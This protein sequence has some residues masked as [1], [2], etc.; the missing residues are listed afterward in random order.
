MKPVSRSHKITNAPKEIKCA[1][2]FFLIL[3]LSMVS[4]CGDGNT[5]LDATSGTGAINFRVHWEG[6]SENQDGPHL[7]DTGDIDCDTVGIDTVTFEA[8]DSNEANLLARQSWS[9]SAHQGSLDGVS[10]GQNRRLLV[11]GKDTL[12]NVIYKGVKT[13]INVVAGGQADV[14]LVTAV[15]EFCFQMDSDEDGVWDCLDNCSNTSNSGQEDEDNDG[16]GDAC[17]SSTESF[18]NSIGM[19]FNYIPSGSFMMGRPEYEYGNDDE[20]QHQVILTKGF[21]MQTTEVTQAQWL[22]IMG[23]NPSAFIHCG[24]DCPVDYISYEDAQEF[25]DA[26]NQKEGGNGHVPPP[27]RSRMGVCGPCGKH[28]GF[29][30][31]KR[32]TIRM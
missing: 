16:I 18:T 24:G 5:E 15:P 3:I 32:D 13:G 20:T 6:A 9:C 10:A 23:T 11:L 12:D 27:F 14:G 22:E 17:D 8:W 19:T 30:Q 29:C 4:G 31:W 2:F 25:I 21:Y 7:A 1:H 26:L 28:H